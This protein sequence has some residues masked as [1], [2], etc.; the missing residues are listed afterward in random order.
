[1]HHLKYKESMHFFSLLLFSEFTCCTNSA[2]GIIMI[3]SYTFAQ[4]QYKGSQTL[5]PYTI[6]QNIS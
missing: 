2:S 6:T 4:V 5:A 1:M 3:A